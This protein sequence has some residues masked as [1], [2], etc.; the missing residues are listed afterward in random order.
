MN[1][2]DILLGSGLDVP[3]DVLAEMEAGIE[4]DALAYEQALRAAYGLPEPT[5]EPEP[6][7]TPE[8]VSLATPRTRVVKEIV[9]DD[10]GLITHVI[11]RIEEE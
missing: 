11:E 3:E 9:R 8:P 7:P 5:P 4:G 10:R 6:E 1:T 2:R